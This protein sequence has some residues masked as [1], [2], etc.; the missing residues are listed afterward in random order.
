MQ[1]VTAKQ[2]ARLARHETLQCMFVKLVDDAEGDATLHAADATPTQPQHRKAAALLKEFSD[3]FPSGLPHGL[4][5]SRTIEHRIELEADA[6]PPSRPTF[7]MSPKEL[8]ELKKQL[9][10]LLAKGL[11]QPSK[12]PYGAPVLF[13]KK[14]DGS[15]RM[16]VDYR[17]LN[18]LT[19]KNKYPLPRIEELLDRLHG[20][21]IFSGLDLVNGYYQV[22]IA[23]GDIPKTAF[24]TRYG[25]YEFLV[26]PFGLTNAPA[27]FM[28][29]MHDLFGPLLDKFVIVFLDDI[30]IF[31][32][33]H[34]RRARASTCAR[35]CK[36]LRDEQVAHQAQQV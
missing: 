26:M 4:P 13:V 12:S 19:I 24:R 34:R 28:H 33:T 7:R 5:P 17:A 31:S 15:V 16:C 27:T 35:C 8:D 14:K 6:Q 23:K 3:V 32:K 11:I 9:D 1:L 10:E 21:K 36:R 30:L 2:L 25:H 22:R 29:L 18:K 20:A